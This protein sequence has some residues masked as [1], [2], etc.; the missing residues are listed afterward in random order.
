M[1]HE[2][3][4]EAVKR[5]KGLPTFSRIRNELRNK[6]GLEIYEEDLKNNLDEMVKEGKLRK[7]CTTI[8]GNKFKGYTIVEEKKERAEEKTKTKE[9][10]IIDEVFS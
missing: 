10:E 2:I 6:F 3:I 8:K 1:D 9:E 4:K 5:V 7:S